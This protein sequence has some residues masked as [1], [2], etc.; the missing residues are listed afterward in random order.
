MKIAIFADHNS[1]S[2]EKRKL[3]KV[4]QS[5]HGRTAARHDG[6]ELWPLPGLAPM[7]RV[8]TSFGDVHAITL[9]KGTMGGFLQRIEIQQPLGG[10]GQLRPL[11]LG[12][13]KVQQLGQ[14]SDR[15][16]M[17]PASLALQPFLEGRIADPD[18]RQ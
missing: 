8:R 2:A 6:L 13:A 14:R 18:P 5:A 17:Q 9:R 12:S 15:K 3:Q 10:R 4:S 16:G 7:T 1:R 11:S